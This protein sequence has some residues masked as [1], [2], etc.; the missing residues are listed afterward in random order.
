MEVV[1]TTCNMCIRRCGIDVYVENG[2][3]VKVAAM[4]NQKE[5]GISIPLEI[6][7]MPKEKIMESISN[8]VGTMNQIRDYGGNIL[9]TQWEVPPNTPVQGFRDMMSCLKRHQ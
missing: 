3:I 1:K 9:I 8:I 5:F 6:L 2:K 4:E 7:S